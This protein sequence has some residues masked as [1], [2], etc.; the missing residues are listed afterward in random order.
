MHEGL[1]LVVLADI[2]DRQVPD[3]GQVDG[4]VK[5]PLA[6]GAVAEEARD[7]GLP[8]RSDSDSAAPGAS[9]SS[10]PTIVDV[11]MTPSSLTEM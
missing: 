10:P 9:D 5:N 6:G 8:S 11:R 2:K 4:L 1:P 7:D 3:R